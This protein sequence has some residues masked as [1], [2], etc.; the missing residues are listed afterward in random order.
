M[1]LT[2]NYNKWILASLSP[3]FNNTLFVF[4][5]DIVCRS[6]SGEADGKNTG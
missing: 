2:T 1:K 6:T 5:K 3:E 4:L